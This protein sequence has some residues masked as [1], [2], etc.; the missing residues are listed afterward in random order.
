MY[1]SFLIILLLEVYHYT[2]WQPCWAYPSYVLHEPISN[3]PE[4]RHSSYF[5][6]TYRDYKKRV[7]RWW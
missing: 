7:G 6:D 3:Q 4:E 5:G 1:L 2:T